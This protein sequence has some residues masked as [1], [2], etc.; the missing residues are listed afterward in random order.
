MQKKT[1]QHNKAWFAIRESISPRKQSLLTLASFIIPLLLWVLVSYIPFIWHPDIKLTISAYRDDVTTVLTPGDRISKTY[2]PQFEDAIREHNKNVINS[3]SGGEPMPQTRRSNIK[4]LRQ[5]APAGAV[6]SGARN[7][8][9][10]DAALYRLWQDLATGAAR[11]TSI[12]LTDENREIVKANWA[13]LSEVVGSEYDSK[14][15]PKEPLLKLIPQ[16][17]PSNPVYLPAP[18]EVIVSG[19]NDFTSKPSNGMPTMWERYRHSI[20]IIF[21]GFIFSC[22][23]GIPLGVLCGTFDF[24]SKLY[25]PFIDFFRYMPAPTFAVIFVAFLGTAD[26][27]KIT[28]VFVGTFFQMVLVIANT[29]R[30]LERPLL[31]AAQ[32]LGA[33]RQQLLRKVIVPGI[34]PSIY[35]DMRILLGWAWTWLVIAE[36]IGEKT[37]L[38]GFISTQGTRYNFD[39]VFPIIILIGLTGFFTDQLLNWLRSLLFPWTEE[40]R[41]SRKGPIKRLI[42][43]IL[44]TSCYLEPQSA[45]STKPVAMAQEGGVK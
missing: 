27:P 25:E 2:F 42:I 41:N 23:V 16:G 26:A 34:L 39:R 7:D 33:A 12:K 45:T 3:R 38:T 21:W 8:T 30:L 11:D 14:L 13:M 28:L 5:L 4:I 15:M 9:L 35:N 29:T 17:V 37:G 43:W 24:F 44:D 31:E 19:W 18:H 10:D 40:A 32:T 6:T 1:K 20:S 36:L 22:L